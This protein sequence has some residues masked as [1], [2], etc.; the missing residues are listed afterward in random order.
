MLLGGNPVFLNFV[1]I[2]VTLILCLIFMDFTF[3]SLFANYVF[4]CI[5][6]FVR[7]IIAW[8]GDRPIFQ[9]EEEQGEWRH[10]KSCWLF[11]WRRLS[12][13]AMIFKNLWLVFVFIYHFV[14]NFSTLLPYLLLWILVLKLTQVCVFDWFTRA[15]I[16][17]VLLV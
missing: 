17:F 3:E 15:L 11:H 10:D 6:C 9:E 12:Y 13:S 14:L 5:I 8:L 4:E 16:Y 1:L 7:A 2:C